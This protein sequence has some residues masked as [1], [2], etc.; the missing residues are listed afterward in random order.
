MS[1]GLQC[2]GYGCFCLLA[3]HYNINF[4]GNDSWSK[5]ALSSLQA[6][7]LL[8][9]LTSAPIISSMHVRLFMRWK[10]HAYTVH[11]DEDRTLT[12]TRLEVLQEL[13]SQQLQLADRTE[14]LTLVTYH[15]LA[16]LHISLCSLQIRS[17]LTDARQFSQSATCYYI[18]IVNIVVSLHYC[19]LYSTVKKFCWSQDLF[20]KEA[21]YVY[22]GSKKR[23]IAKPMEARSRH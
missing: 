7:L 13:K 2:W 23:Y 16:L 1:Q 15:L 19:M 22:Q 21:S 17:C 3:L 11:D 12:N 18:H 4:S 6:T 20:L 8:H 5:T 10:E 9:I 14:R